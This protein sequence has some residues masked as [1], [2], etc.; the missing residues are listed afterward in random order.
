MAHMSDQD[1]HLSD[2]DRWYATEGDGV[3][4]VVIQAEGEDGHGMHHA[5]AECG[6]Q[7]TAEM[8]ARALNSRGAVDLLR[9]LADEAANAVCEPARF[10]QHNL[11]ITVA[12][13]RRHLLGQ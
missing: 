1:S 3:P 9:E 6:T 11:S 8:I 13:A 12:R 7:A 4:W 2:V 10:D 5:I